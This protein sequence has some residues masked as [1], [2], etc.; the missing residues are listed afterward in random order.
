MKT[1]SYP[2][3]TQINKLFPLDTLI[4]RINPL[5]EQ[6][7]KVVWTSGCFDI[8]H[9]GHVIYLKFAKNTGD[10]LIVGLNR[11]ASVQSLKGNDRPLMS[12][13]ERALVLD[14]IVYIDYLIVFHEPRPLDIL[15]RL[16]P[17]I[18]VKG[19]DYTIDTIDQ[20][21]RHIVEMNGGKIVI[22]PCL[23]KIS[24]SRLI[25]KIIS[26]TVKSATS[27]RNLNKD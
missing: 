22:A 15:S 20:E 11:D 24:T 16:K 8:L 9:A 1:L 4:E 26:T 19:G 14:S 3:L 21:E 17:D 23:E 10:I 13:V 18:Y 12:Q 2:D 5:R 25:E 7:A 27:I 6:G